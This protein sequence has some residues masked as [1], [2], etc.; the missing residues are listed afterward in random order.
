MKKVS[1]ILTTYQG[2]K[3]IQRSLDAICNQLGRDNLFELELIVVDDCS[4]DNTT[5]ILQQNKIPFIRHESNSGG[6]NKG[7]NTG[8]K[9]ATGDYICIADQDD[10][11]NTNRIMT[12]LPH[13]ERVPI[14]TSGYTVI[15]NTQGRGIRRILESKEEHVFFKRNSTFL[16]RLSRSHSGQTTYLGSIL[17]RK[18]LKTILFEEHFGLADG[19]WLLRLFHEQESIEVVDSLYC[20]FVDGNNLSLLESYRRKD[21]YYSLMMLENYQPRFLKETRIAYF[22]IYGSRARYYYLLGN[23]RQARFYFSRSRWNLKTIL[24]YLTSFVGHRWVRKKFN[25]FG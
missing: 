8:L 14:V 10:V 13:L 7:R 11:W 21:F 20:R 25:V 2:E 1:V 19:D 17:F 9:L 24:Y 18:E 22:K 6:P 23:M 5:L 15:D 4:T 16:K 12:L 3:T